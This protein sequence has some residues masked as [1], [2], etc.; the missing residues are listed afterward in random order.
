M[1]IRSDNNMAAVHPP[2]SVLVTGGTGLVGAYV[3]RDLVERGY[4][5]KAIRRNGFLPAF[6]DQK[7]FDQVQWLDGDVLDPCA[8][9]E[10]MENTDAVIHSAA[11]VS[12][13]KKDRQQMF[14]VNTEGTANVINM[15][16]EKNIK[17][18]IHVSS[19][20]A[21]GKKNNGERVTEE[22]KWKDDKHRTGYAVSKHLAE[23][24]VW[25]GIA[26]GLPSVIVNPST[27]LGYGDWNRSS[28][29]L[30]KNVHEGFSWYSKGVTGFVDVEDVSKAIVL[31][32]ATNIHS[33]RF[34]VSGDNWSYK[35]LLD[36]LADGFGKK[37][38]YLEATPLLAGIA[39]RWEKVRSFF[40]GKKPLLTKESAR[41]G[42]G[43]TQFDSSKLLRTLPD[44]RF[45]DL[46]QTIKKACS[47]Y[48]KN[49]TL[50]ITALCLCFCCLSQNFVIAGKVSDSATSLPLNG[51]SVFAQ[52]TT[53]GTIS[54][55]D[56]NFMIRLPNGGYD[57][58]F[59][60]TGYETK[61]LRIS[62]SQLP[63]DSFVVA[64][65]QIDQSM[66]AVAIVLS[67]EVTDGWE[68]FGQFFL[69]NF[70]GTTPN[71]AH[72]TILNP[73]SLHFYYTKNKKRHRLK[74]TS[75]EDIYVRNEALG[76]LVRYRLDSF[77]YDY[78]SNISQY[79][80]YPFFIELDTTQEVKDEW[81][82]N[83]ARTYLGSRLHF[84]SAL[85]DSIV[86]QEG[87]T[88]EKMGANFKSVK[89]SVLGDL[90]DS[91]LYQADSNTVV[92]NWDGRYRISYKSVF[93]DPE[94]LKEFKLPANTRSQVTLLDVNGGFAVERNGYFYEQYDVVNTGYWAWKKLA[95]ALPYD[96]QYE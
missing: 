59:S 23:M 6:I 88:V 64:L 37:K 83:R 80:G 36:T 16:I 28:L 62:N 30:F 87:F 22:Y 75:P 86:T 68:R 4:T 31:L 89:G 55:E 49:I 35:M 84:M 34:I 53:Q 61:T 65:P 77:S 52:N 38:P 46:H 24:E 19:V 66:E 40:S 51:A 70:I 9:G 94:F 79:T 5:V 71:A 1:N 12:F 8:L 41:V 17:K 39:W 27:I 63:G 20:S 26:E 56:G 73:D 82:K 11:I 78:N 25:R 45:T 3:I 72:C 96:Y 95:E 60:Y 90:Y 43:N 10:A 14:Q 13:H 85:Y 18:F 48:M 74:V 57:L 91:T 69:D 81:K 21:I 67:N 33:E 58:V 76:Y 54:G 32:L 44:F 50:L 7:I 93:P 29:A 42:R 2:S 47:S 15:A 92:I